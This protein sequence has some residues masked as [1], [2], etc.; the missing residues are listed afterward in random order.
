MRISDWSSDVCSSDLARSG[1]VTR[2]DLGERHMAEARAPAR[3]VFAALQR[4]S[5][6][7]RG[8]GLQ[9]CAQRRQLRPADTLRD[10]VEMQPARASDEPQIGRA[11]WWERVCQYVYNSVV[12]VALKKTYKTMYDTYIH[13]VETNIHYQQH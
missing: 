6:G 1:A 5:I 2:D 12:A 8:I 9:P 7:D 3:R 13:K 4:G 10:L 11:S